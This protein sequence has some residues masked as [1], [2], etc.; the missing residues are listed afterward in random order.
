M[1]LGKHWQEAKNV[2]VYCLQPKKGNGVNS[3]RYTLDKH[4]S[5]LQ[6]HLF[7]VLPSLKQWDEAFRIL[8]E[9]E[10]TATWKKEAFKKHLIKLKGEVPQEESN[11]Q[12]LQQIKVTEQEK[13]EHLITK[14]ND[15]DNLTEKLSIQ[16]RGIHWFTTDFIINFL[17]NYKLWPFLSVLIVFLVFGVWTGKTK[18]PIGPR[19]ILNR[20][21]L[22]KRYNIWT[23]V[24][25]T[26]ASLFSY[27][28]PWMKASP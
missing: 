22:P 17:R 9:D 15:G 19:T 16:D 14:E 20:K 12:Q 21:R 18:P 25:D 10:F 3:L 1:V 5:I 27:P 28:N 23:S 8:D 13:I 4:E 11:V 26:I 24:K 7:Y 2:S 6:L